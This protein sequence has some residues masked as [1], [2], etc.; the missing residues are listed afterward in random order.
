M[1][2][3]LLETVD[4]LGARGEIVEVARGYARNFLLPK[5]LAK[6]PNAALIQEVRKK[7]ARIQAEESAVKA[8]RMSEAQVLA[9]VSLEIAMKAGKEGHLYGSVGPRQ[10]AELLKKLG[11]AVEEK[12]VVLD[13]PLKDL[14]DYDVNIALHPEVQVPVKVVIV[15]EEET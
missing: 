7:A 13:P 12:H 4:G 3:L 8:V 15:A 11:H 1:E 6:V 5:K 2:L 10:I 9:G 14:G